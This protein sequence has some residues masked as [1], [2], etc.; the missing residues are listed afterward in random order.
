MVPRACITGLASLNVSV[1]D[2]SGDI[3]LTFSKVP[4]AVRVVGSSGN[5]T[6]VLPHGSTAYDVTA[7]TD[8]GQR[9]VNVPTNSS[10]LMDWSPC[11]R[12]RRPS[13]S[14][15]IGFVAVL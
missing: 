1:S 11:S 4:D 9:T 10:S 3:T 13:T 6:V 12:A 15:P 2:D 8:S 5:I 7:S 14:S